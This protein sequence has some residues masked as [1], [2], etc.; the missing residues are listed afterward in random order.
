MP[1]NQRKGVHAGLNAVDGHGD[2]FAPA[3]RAFW[4]MVRAWRRDQ[5][6]SLSHG[7]GSA[8]VLYREP[9]TMTSP[10]RSA[11]TA[12]ATL[13]CCGSG[14]PGR[15]GSALS[16]HRFLPARII[17]PS[18]PFDHRGIDYRILDEPSGRLS[19]PRMLSRMRWAAS[20]RPFRASFSAMTEMVLAADY[21]EQ[22]RSLLI[23]DE[24]PRMVAAPDYPI[25]AD[26]DAAGRS[27][28]SHGA[29]CVEQGFDT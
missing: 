26:V 23:I 15:S 9:P 14:Y 25:G 24:T 22:V 28:R 21:P 8:C 2:A 19:G 11:A 16:L 7:A 18:N 20:G 12:R 1:R 29:G 17:Q 6:D 10:T 3:A 13:S 27:D 4:A 5:A